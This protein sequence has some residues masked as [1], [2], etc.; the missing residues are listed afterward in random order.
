MPSTISVN[1]SKATETIANEC[2]A[3]IRK[4]QIAFGTITRIANLQG[5][6]LL[7]MVL[8]MVLYL[9]CYFQFEIFKIMTNLVCTIIQQEASR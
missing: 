6:R 2:I 9:L 4:Q 7:F 8:C 5:I 1:C 3:Q